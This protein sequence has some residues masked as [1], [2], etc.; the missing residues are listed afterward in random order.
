MLKV[1]LNSL[2]KSNSFRYSPS[3]V[4]ERF[5][6]FRKIVLIPIAKKYQEV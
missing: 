4:T 1:G 3:S 5:S 2:I 6:I